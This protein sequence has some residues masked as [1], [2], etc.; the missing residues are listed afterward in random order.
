MTSWG[1]F[2]SWLSPA[3]HDPSSK[4]LLRNMA[5]VPSHWQEIPI[6][7][8][9]VIEPPALQVTVRVESWSIH[10]HP[11][12]DFNLTLYWT[13]GP[14]APHVNVFSENRQYLEALGFWAAG[15]PLSTVLG[16]LKST[17]VRDE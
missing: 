8:P 10:V 7:E 1:T 15:K 2:W 17:E 13:K 11:P 9:L 6:P 12:S 3:R 4:Q 5:E 16:A 14:G